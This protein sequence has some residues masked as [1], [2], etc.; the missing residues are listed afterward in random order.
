MMNKPK[1][2]KNLQIFVGKTEHTI[3]YNCK[4]NECK[5]T[6]LCIGF[7]ESH[8]GA[9]I[10]SRCSGSGELHKKIT[11]KGFTDR[12]IKRVF[13]L[14]LGGIIGESETLKLSDFGGQSYG[15]WLSGKPFPPKSENR[16]STCP[17]W[18]YQFADHNLK[19]Q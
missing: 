12:K 18:W 6:G 1:H 14:N 9:I 17:A 4:C 2:G 15:K 7:A 8:G 13:Q 16:L 11:Y 3:G 5:G 19:P 10:C